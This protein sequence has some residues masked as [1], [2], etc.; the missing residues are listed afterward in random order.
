MQGLIIGNIANI[1]KKKL[2]KSLFKAEIKLIKII[3][4]LFCNNTLY[5]TLL[6]L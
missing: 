3:P 5:N 4:F 2:N 6:F 1:Y